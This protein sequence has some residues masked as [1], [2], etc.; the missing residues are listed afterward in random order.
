MYSEIYSAAVSACLT[1]LVARIAMLL[2]D[3]DGE[4]RA[5]AFIESCRQE[6]E[7]RAWLR[8]RR[9]TDG[10]SHPVRQSIASHS[11]PY[12]QA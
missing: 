12:E 6:D 3:I 7:L 5:R 11:S 4:E 2:A 1:P 9:G 10:T 8:S